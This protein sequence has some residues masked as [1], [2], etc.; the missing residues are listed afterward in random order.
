MLLSNALRTKNALNVLVFHI[1]F[2]DVINQGL[3]QEEK[4]DISAEK[5]TLISTV[6]QKIVTQA[7]SQMIRFILCFVLMFMFGY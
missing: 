1:E 2:N 6:A 3:I 5:G 7:W 4:G